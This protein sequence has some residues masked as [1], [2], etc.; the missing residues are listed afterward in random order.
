M[1][2]G[3]QS[4]YP[5]PLIGPGLWATA[6]VVALVTLAT[7]AHAQ[8]SYVEIIEN[9]GQPVY[10]GQPVDWKYVIHNNNP[11]GEKLTQIILRG[12]FSSG[13][14]RFSLPIGWSGS[15]SE[16]QVN[17]WDITFTANIPP[18]YIGSGSNRSIDLGTGRHATLPEIQIGTLHG[19]GR[20][21]GAGYTPDTDFLGPVGFLPKLA[22][23]SRPG[24]ADNVFACIIRNGTGY[25]M[26]QVTLPGLLSSTPPTVQAPF[27]WQVSV[28]EHDGFYDVT[29]SSPDGIPAYTTIDVTLATTA[30]ARAVSG[31]GPL[32]ARG[33]ITL[34]AEVQ[35]SFDGPAVFRLAI[36]ADRDGDVDASDLDAFIACAAGPAIPV[37][38]AA[39]HSYDLDEDNDV[40]QGDFGRFQRCFSGP[41]DTYVLTCVD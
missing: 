20:L 21:E 1:R 35:G 7:T 12:V 37:E 36:D 29:L 33:Q 25:P 23:T 22:V 18:A 40:D 8:S 5:T 17:L 38:D 31:L 26:T 41:G 10:N 14:P 16:Q 3:R 13:L 34:P 9:D 2:T 11:W 19:K 28:V 24:T 27:G 15:A 6:L 39:C 4:L 32:T 30:P